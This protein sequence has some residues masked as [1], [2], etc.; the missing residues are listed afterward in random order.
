MRYRELTHNPTKNIVKHFVDYVH[1]KLKLKGP[2]PSI[3][4]SEDEQD[5]VQQHHTGSYGIHNNKIWVYIKGRALV[6]ILRTVAHELVHA[7]QDEQKLLRHH[8][9]PG[10]KHEVDADAIAGTIVKL[11]GAE[12]PE[13]FRTQP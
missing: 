11:Y 4:F 3:D 9:A 7:K 2:V 8:D 12:H 5:A 10:S 13:I 6:D 1:D